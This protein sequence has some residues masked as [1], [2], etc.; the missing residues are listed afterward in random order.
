[1]AR[2]GTTAKDAPADLN[3]KALAYPVG[4]STWGHHQYDEFF[5]QSLFGKQMRPPERHVAIDGPRPNIAVE[6]TGKMKRAY[7]PDEPPA[8]A[9]DSSLIQPAKGT[10]SEKPIR[11]IFVA[12]TDFAHNEFFAMYRNADDR[13]SDDAIR[14][15]AQLRNVQFI[16]NLVDSLSGEKGYLDLRTRR[17]KP[18]PLTALVKVLDEAQ[19]AFRTAET[20]AQTSADEKISKLKADFEKRLSDIQNKTGLDENAKAQL[21]AQV[22]RAAQR[23]LDT[24]TVGVERERD[25]AIRAASIVRERQVEDVRGKV[26]TMALGLPSV[27]L[28]MIALFV[29]ARRRR[30]ETLTIPSSRKRGS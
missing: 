8:E 9:Q 3:V 30:E 14:F 29:W 10:L 2:R 12:D 11:V 24:D 20:K 26:R 7:G 5:I 23:Q 15:L 18:R 16:S 21:R 13:F 22:Q 19:L 4:Q 28:A 25:L 1:M 6:V 17:P 27:V